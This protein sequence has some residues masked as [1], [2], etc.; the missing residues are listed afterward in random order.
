MGNSLIFPAP[1]CKHTINSLQPFYHSITVPEERLPKEKSMMKPTKRI[2]PA[3]YIKTGIKSKYLML[4]FHGNSD[5]LGRSYHRLLEYYEHFQ[6]TEI[7]FWFKIYE[8]VQ[9]DRHSCS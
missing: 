9:T 6:V 4:Y 3:L 7:S 5:D 1:K 8:F 2:I